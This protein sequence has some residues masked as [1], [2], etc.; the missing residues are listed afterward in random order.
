MVATDNV[1]LSV[2][3]IARTTYDRLVLDVHVHTTI[4]RRAFVTH[5]FP[6]IAVET[7][8]SKC[9]QVLVAALPSLV[10]PVQQ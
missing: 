5:V 2:C 1:F 6:I 9:I 4:L 7:R 3:L 10:I 8:C